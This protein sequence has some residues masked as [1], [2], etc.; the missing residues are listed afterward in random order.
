MT[1]DPTAG[2]AGPAAAPGSARIDAWTQS[3]CVWRAQPR[4]ALAVVGRGQR[5]VVADDVAH[6]DPEAAAQPARE[7]QRRPQLARV[8]QHVG[9][10]EADVLDADRRVVQADGVAAHERQRDHLHDR[11]VGADD[12]VRADA[13]Q[14][15]ELDVGDVGREGVEDGAGRA[16][17]RDVLDDDL[18][19]A[20]AVVVDAVVAARVGAHLALAPRRVGDVV[21]HDR[22]RRRARR[23]GSIGSSCIVR[24]REHSASTRRGRAPTP[25]GWTSSRSS[26]A[27]CAPLRERKPPWFKVPAPGQRALPR[28]A[29]AHRGREPAHGL[30]G[31]RLPEHRRVLGARHRDV[32]DPRRHVHAALRLLQRQDRQAD[33]ERPAR[34]RARRAQRR[35]HGPAPRGHHERRPR[36]P[37]RLRRRRLRR[38]HPP[39]PPPGAAT[40][41]SRS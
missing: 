2:T 24:G 26:A 29:R 21:A 23:P 40:A 13:G 15:V 9:V 20:Q 11:P 5:L 35:A 16:G 18:G 37:A 22:R 38:R 10:A 28:A 12:E 1:A 33:V 36:R 41:R 19:R 7:A 6:R 3:P 27:T 8:A 30:P 39:D 34:A 4:H 32:H 25:A 31:G 14:L 17:D